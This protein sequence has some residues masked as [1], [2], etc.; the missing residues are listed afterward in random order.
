M[1]DTI[2]DI[3]RQVYQFWNITHSRLPIERMTDIV[4]RKIKKRML[5][6]Q[7]TSGNFLLK[8]SPVIYSDT[9]TWQININDL[10]TVIRVEMKPKTS[11]SDADWREISLVDYGDWSRHLGRFDQFASFY[12]NAPESYFINVNFEPGPQMFRLV[13]ETSGGWRRVFDDQTGLQDIFSPLLFAD[14]GIEAGFAVNDRSPD[15]MRERNDKVMY[16]KSELSSLE[17]RWDKWTKMDKTQSIG[18]REAFDAD[19]NHCINLGGYT[20]WE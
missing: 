1:S 10:S 6:L 20:D 15:W 7:L 17:P 11:L 13:Y 8:V 16:L 2:G 3:I 18:Q 5:D 19:T 9:A 4:N 14:V 12:G